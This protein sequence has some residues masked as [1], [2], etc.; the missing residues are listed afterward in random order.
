MGRINVEI[1]NMFLIAAQAVKLLDLP[2]FVPPTPATSI[3]SQ[4]K[5]EETETCWRL[6]RFFQ[7]MWHDWNE[8][9]QEESGYKMQDSKKEK[10]NKKA[11]EITERHWMCP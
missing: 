10:E 3:Q 11:Q 6:V 8:N 7:H 2:C 1:L 5:E 9:V 4:L